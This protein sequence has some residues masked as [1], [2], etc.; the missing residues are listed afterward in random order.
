M[1]SYK[2]KQSCINIDLLNNQRNTT[3]GKNKGYGLAI[4]KKQLKKI[5]N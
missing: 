1:H 3:K 5:V 2:S 4:A